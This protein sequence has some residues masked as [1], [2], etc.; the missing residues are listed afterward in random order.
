ML[1]YEDTLSRSGT[2]KKLTIILLLFTSVTFAYRLPHLDRTE[3]DPLRLSKL[4]QTVSSFFKDIDT[5]EES[6]LKHNLDVTKRKTSGG[7]NPNTFF[8][9]VHFASKPKSTV[10]NQNVTNVN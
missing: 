5:R 10:Q 3:T 6:N 8:P 9:Y 4:F 7:P 2:M 1:Y